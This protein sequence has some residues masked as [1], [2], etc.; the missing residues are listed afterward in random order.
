MKKILLCLM[1]INLSYSKKE[2]KKKDQKNNPEIK[3]KEKNNDNIPLSYNL[4]SSIDKI[5][6]NKDFSYED[7]NN[8]FKENFNI[9]LEEKNLNEEE[10]TKILNC[11]TGLIL[12]WKFPN[13]IGSFLGFLENK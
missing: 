11:L 12:G 7:K 6:N 1:L 2:D 10:K 9:I 5:I 4:I 13:E 3:I 8:I